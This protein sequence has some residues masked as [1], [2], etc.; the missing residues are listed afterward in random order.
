VTLETHVKIRLLEE[1]DIPAIESALE[2]MGW[3]PRLLLLESYIFEQIKGTRIILVA[4]V[5]EECAGYVTIKWKSDY[6]P[7][8][9]KGIPE[10]V[11]L[12]VFSP[13]RHRRV[14]SA[15]V[16]KAEELIFDRSQIAGIGVGLFSDYGPAQRMYVKRGYVPDGL[17]IAYK[18]VHAKRGQILPID[19]DLVLYF[20]KERKKSN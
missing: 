4:F 9:D 14:A 15:L 5:K 11:D 3:R 12:N 13:F 6:P 7:F 8:A 16:D 2:M 19:D 17:G 10:I 18:G 1:Q 20:T